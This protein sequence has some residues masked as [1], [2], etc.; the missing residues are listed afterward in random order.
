M[1]DEFEFTIDNER[2]FI[3]AMNRLKTVSSDFRKPFSF[4]ANDFYK[5]NKII[6]G[7]KGPGLY[8]PLGGFRYR[9]ELPSGKTRRKAA[10]E[11]KTRRVKFAYPLLIGATKRLAKSVLSRRAS[12][13]V[14]FLNE[15][16]LEMG[17]EVKSF[18]GFNYPLLHQEGG[19]IHPKRKFIFIDGGADVSKSS[20]IAGRRE[21][22]LNILNTEVILKLTGDIGLT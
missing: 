20:S 4:I 7:L 5:S 15:S 3:R 16:T 10:E 8:N 1:A 11:Q 2:D 13:S 9:E 6:F 22:W 21:R 14:F 12:G 18:T 19:K 17:T